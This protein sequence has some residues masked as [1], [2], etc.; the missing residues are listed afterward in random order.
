MVLDPLQFGRV[1]NLN[2]DA[3][4]LAKTYV[5]NF[6][7]WINSVPQLDREMELVRASVTGV[8]VEKDGL[9]LKI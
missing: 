9:F 5:I 8:V 4:A 2:P 6:I 7:K 1:V 3:A